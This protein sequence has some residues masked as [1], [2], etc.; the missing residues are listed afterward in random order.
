MT[1][2]SGIS[3]YPGVNINNITLRGTLDAD[4]VFSDIC[5]SMSNYPLVC[6]IMSRM[7]MRSENKGDSYKVI[8]VLLVVVSAL[9]LVFLFMLFA[10]RKIAKKEMNH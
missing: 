5:N 4:F 3:Y 7:Q 1:Y 9:V 8:Y 6:Q 10:Y 2:S